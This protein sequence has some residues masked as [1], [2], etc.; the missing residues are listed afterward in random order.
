M[1]KKKQKEIPKYKPFFA[2]ETRKWEIGILTSLFISIIFAIGIFGFGWF[3]Q[4]KSYVGSVGYYEILLDTSSQRVLIN[5]QIVELGGTYVD[6]KAWYRENPSLNIIKGERI[7]VTINP[8][9]EIAEVTYYGA[10]GWKVQRVWD[11]KTNM[12]VIAN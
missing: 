9:G 2:K 5:L 3:P 10:T 4:P 8:D 11:G 7:G 6:I 12:E 1:S